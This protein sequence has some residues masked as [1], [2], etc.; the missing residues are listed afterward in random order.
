[1][2]LLLLLPEK[3][4]QQQQQQQQQQQEQER[5]QQEQEQEQPEQ[6]QNRS[7]QRAQD[8][9]RRTDL[10]PR[11]PLNTTGLRRVTS[12]NNSHNSKSPPWEANTSELNVQNSKLR[13][14]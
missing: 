13:T 10:L 12:E 11:C 6:E 3:Q 7:C 4:P 14:K 1:M 5:E 8:I 9:M 2:G